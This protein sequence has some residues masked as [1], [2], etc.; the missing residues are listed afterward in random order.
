MIVTIRG[1]AS[2]IGSYTMEDYC[3]TT[4]AICSFYSLAGLPS[5]EWIVLRQEAPTGHSRLSPFSVAPLPPSLAESAWVLSIAQ[6][7]FDQAIHLRKSVLQRGVGD[8]N[9][10][11]QS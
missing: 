3:V 6:Q 10:P 11:D 4:D 9:G 8:E 7:S 1:P 2:D 5:G